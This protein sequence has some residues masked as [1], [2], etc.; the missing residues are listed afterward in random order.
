MQLGKSFWFELRY[1]LMHVSTWLLLVGFFLFGF[2]ILRLVTL[3]D[4]THLNAPG[5]IAFFTVFGSVIWI[6]IGGVV[7][8]DAATRDLMTRM[9]PLVYTTPVSKLSYLGSRFLAALSLN[10]AMM[11]ILYLGFVLSL[12]GPGGRDAMLG[13]FRLESYLTNWWFIAFP[14][15]F[16]ATSIQFSLAALSGRAIAAYV[17]SMAIIIFSQLGGT[18]VRFALEW[19]LMGSLMDLLGTSIIAEME[20]WTPL[21]K[22][23]RMIALEGTWLWNR[24]AWFAAGAVFLSYTYNRFKLAHPASKKIFKFRSSPVSELREDSTPNENLTKNHV[25]PPFVNRSFEFRA[26]LLQT[27]A[28]T[29]SAFWSIAGTRIGLP[30]VGMLALGTGLFATE[31]MEWLG[32]PLQPRT[33][34]VLR[35]LTPSLN[36]YRTPWIIIPF[37]IIFFSGEI[38]WREREGGLN[39]LTDTAPVSEWVMF[40]G[41]FGGLTLIILVW[42]TFILAAGIL[43]QVMLGYYNFELAVYIKALFGIQL[44]NYLLFALLTLSIH[45]VVNQKYIA[46]MVAFLVY[47]VILFSSTIGVE[48]HMLIYASDTGWSYSDMRGFGPSIVP[49]F[50]FKL[51]W[52]SWA[53]L[54]ASVAILF[55]VRGKEV[56]P[57]SRLGLAKARFPK[58]KTVSSIAIVLVTLSGFFIFY[59]TNVMNRYVGKNERME[60]RAAYE[61]KYGRYENATQPILAGTVLSADL[62]PGRGEGR[63]QTTYRLSNHST[64]VIDSIHLSMFPQTEIQDI[65]FDRDVSAAIIDDDL[66]YR[67]YALEEAL[68]PGETMHMHFTVNICPRGFSNDGV[69]LSVVPNGSYIRARHWMPVIGYDADRQIRNRRDR[70]RYGLPDRPERPSLYD[71]EAR[72]NSRHANPMTFEATVSTDQ[73]Q[74]AIAPGTLT[75]TWT[76]GDRKY[77]HYEANAPIINDYAIFSAKYAVR[78]SEW[79]P[80]SVSSDAS[81]SD[82]SAANAVKPVTIEVYYHPEH[83]ALIVRMIESVRASLELYTREFGRYPYTQFRVVERPG[84]GRGMHADPMTIDYQE[85]YSLMSPRPDGLDL[86]YHI[87]A[88]EVAHQWWGLYLSPAAVEGSGVLVESMATYSAM[89]VVEESLGY[90]HLM[91][92]LSQMRMEYEVPRSRAAPP[93]VRANNAF[94]NYRKGPFALFAL[95]NYVGKSQ[96]NNALRKILEGYS[97]EPPLPTTLDL[98]RELKAVTPDSLQYLV[99]DLFAANTFWELKAEK[100]VATKTPS[101]A[102]AWEVTLVLNARK[103]TVDTVGVEAEIPMNDWLEVGV[104]GSRKQSERSD[105]ILH[106]QK[107]RITSGRNTIVVEVSEP[108]S[109]AGVDP[110]NLMIDLDPDDNIKKIN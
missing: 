6:V 44:I 49:W 1:Q 62:Y 86:P 10:S 35:V 9:H 3:T 102:A 4:E 17:A 104:Y 61:K 25:S 64:H 41:R 89:Q 75:R 54:L 109:R 26:Q 23:T 37:L 59:N 84:P 95:R 91:R 108:P 69:D 79:L 43:N 40:A 92:Y 96:V 71:A 80:R 99:H 67:V 60:H 98:Y 52:L 46:H 48:H 53:F 31:Y 5:T 97:P 16:V 74:T 101:K 85:G 11:I 45:A 24:V 28:I 47:G 87:M 57:L 14:T 19:K 82:S 65:S 30:L 13:P 94:M 51:Y 22:N 27:L 8:G 15:V 90:D 12:Y 34:E 93:L 56:H 78:S 83:N 58:Y 110:N 18:T 73:D 2:G 72:N 68:L 105:P 36:S 20:G 77:F 33:E 39:E 76:I 88:H 29:K 70:E 7:A 103:I 106:L 32:V 50:W 21:D 42:V 107:H 38:A 63:I 100:V 66:G 81:G 55:C